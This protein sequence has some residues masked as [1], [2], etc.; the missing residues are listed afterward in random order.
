MFTLL[1]KELGTFVLLNLAV[2]T[3]SQP[4]DIDDGFFNQEIADQNLQGIPEIEVLEEIPQRFKEEGIEQF[5]ILPIEPSTP[6]PI[7]QTNIAH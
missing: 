4:L 5:Y 6:P 7:N 2:A 3:L 1:L